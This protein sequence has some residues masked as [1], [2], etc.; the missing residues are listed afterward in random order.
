VRRP[1]GI[2][3]EFAIIASVMIASFVLA[4]LP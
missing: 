4:L 3:L 2:Q 1:T